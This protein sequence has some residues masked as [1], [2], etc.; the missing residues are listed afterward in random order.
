MLSRSQNRST[1]T[2]PRRCRGLLSREITGE[3]FG[4]YAFLPC[5][6]SIHWNIS[7]W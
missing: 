7:D 1:L 5:L 2:Y 4:G 6:P 3:V